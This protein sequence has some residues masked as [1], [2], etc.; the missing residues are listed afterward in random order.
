MKAEIHP[1]KF[2]SASEIEKKGA[3]VTDFLPGAVFNRA[4]FPRRNR[5]IAG[6]AHAN[7]VI[8]SAV[9]GGSMNTADLAHQYGR[10]LFAVP[11]R[12][13]DLKSGGCH[14]LL[15]QQKAQLLT[16]KSN[17]LPFPTPTRNI[18]NDM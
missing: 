11:G 14:Q 12:P 8:E 5:L 13:S 2:I 18:K 7:V 1:D 16:R 3:L 4:N 6:M 15:F 9:K 17:P 10:E